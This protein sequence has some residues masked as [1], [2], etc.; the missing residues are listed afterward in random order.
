VI[1]QR[2]QGFGRRGME[3]STVRR[4]RPHVISRDDETARSTFHG[5]HVEVHWPKYAAVVAAM[6]SLGYL[7]VDGQRYPFGLIF[8][9][10]I[11]GAISYF[12]MNRLRKALNHV[13][14][15]RTGGFRSP[16]YMAGAAAGFLFFIYQ[17]FITPQMILGVEWGVQTAFAD[18]VQSEDL[19]AV[20]MLILKA[21]G[22]MVGGGVLF[23][24]VAK[25]LRGDAGAPDTRK[26]S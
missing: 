25:R 26:S 9:P 17:T 12:T 6:F 4:E 7:L 8:V 14:I 16:A 3:P 1:E 22:F 11:F 19:P 24:F 20:G 15:L 23:E 10:V 2:K 13:H 5:S 21:A 18:G